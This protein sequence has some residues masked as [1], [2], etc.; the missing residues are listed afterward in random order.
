MLVVSLRAISAGEEL[1]REK[2]MPIGCI[3]HNEIKAIV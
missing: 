3:T 1:E 2:N